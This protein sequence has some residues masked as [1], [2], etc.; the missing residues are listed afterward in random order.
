MA[1]HLDNPDPV[2]FPN[3][4]LFQTLA[5][6]VNPLF[7]FPIGELLIFKD[8]AGLMGEFFGG[9]PKRVP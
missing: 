7:G 2:S 4:Q 5:Q 3:P 6:P 9:E 8:D 1:I